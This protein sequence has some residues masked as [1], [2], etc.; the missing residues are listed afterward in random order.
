MKIASMMIGFLYE[1]DPKSYIKLFQTQISSRKPFEV[2]D[3]IAGLTLFD[4]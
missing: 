3:D 2:N 1:L 4:T